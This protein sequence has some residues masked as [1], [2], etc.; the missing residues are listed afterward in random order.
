MLD[1]KFSASV[2]CLELSCLQCFFLSFFVCAGRYAHPGH[3]PFRH[4]SHA[5]QCAGAVFLR[6]LHLR[7]RR[8]AAVG[9]ASE[10]P[11]FHGRRR[12][13]V[14]RSDN[15]RTSQR[16]DAESSLFSKV[17]SP[18]ISS[19]RVSHQFWGLGGGSISQIAWWCLV[20]NQLSLGGTKRF[21]P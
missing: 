15:C 9:G 5:G 4:A 21:F 7:H 12:Q 8:R 13:D 3:S 10:K 17:C 19:F 6:V 1:C 14:S 18:L 2:Y 11:L 16:L 20:C